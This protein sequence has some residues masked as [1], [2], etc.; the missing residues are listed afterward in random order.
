MLSAKSL[1]ARG[2]ISPKQMQKLAVLKQTRPGVPTKMAPFEQKTKDEGQA[3][4]KGHSLANVNEIDSHQTQKLGKVGRVSKGGQARGGT[5]PHTGHINRAA[6]TK[7]A[8]PHGA[9]FKKG[10]AKRKVGVSG[11]APQPSGPEYGGPSSRKYG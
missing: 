1:A 9:K 5:V 10:E 4:G 11:P 3:H 6:F 7:P 2:A 8:N